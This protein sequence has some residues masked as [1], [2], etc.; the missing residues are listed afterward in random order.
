[1]RQFEPRKLRLT[2]FLERQ[3]KVTEIP[4]IQ[5]SVTIELERAQRMGDSLNCV[6]LSVRPVVC[7]VDLPLITGAVVMTGADPIHDRIAQLHVFVLHI[8]LRSQHMGPVGE[9]TSTHPPEQCEVLL[10]G[11]STERALNAWFP[12]TTTLRG[13]GFTVLLVNVGQLLLDQQLGP[14]VQLLKVIAGK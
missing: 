3:R 8:D 13:D 9:I 4:V 14:L 6:T 10:G 7:R 12:V 1:M 2:R 11:S 5:R